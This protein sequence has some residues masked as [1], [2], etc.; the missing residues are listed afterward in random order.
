MQSPDKE[1]AT[2]LKIEG[3][4]A[5]VITNKSASCKECG[6]AQAGIC[7]KKGSGIVLRVD[8]AMNARQ[9]DTVEL[10]L[11]RKTHVKGLFITFILP[12]LALMVF[13]YI[14]HV[15]SQYVEIKGLD[16]MAGITGL[17]ISI[18]YF[19]KKIR[20]LDKSEQLHITKILSDRA[21]YEIGSSSEE[22][23]YYRAFHGS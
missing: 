20:K 13:S 19:Y 5:T 11:S 21:E 7:G 14:G 17:I 10:G 18:V 23:D 1:T 2:V 16:A 12:V 4:S 3:K 6:K 22:I 9:G 15:L 8:N